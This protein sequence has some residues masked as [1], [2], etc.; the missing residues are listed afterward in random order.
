MIPSIHEAPAEIRPNISGAAVPQGTP[1]E[2][3]PIT[4]LPMVN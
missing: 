2:T 1:Q 4:R 3:V